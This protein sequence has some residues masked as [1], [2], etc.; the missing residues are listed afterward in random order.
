MRSVR[1]EEKSLKKLDEDKG[2]GISSQIELYFPLGL[3]MMMAMSSMF[4]GAV[5]M[6]S[7]I[8]EKNDRIV[9]II[10]SSISARSLMIGKL[11]GYGILGLFQILIWLTSVLL[12]ANIF[13]DISLDPLL[14]IKTLY[15]FIYFIFGFTMVASINA[16]I[17]SATKDVQ[18]G[19]HSSGL[20]VI[21]PIIP[22]YFSAAILNNPSGTISRL[23]S[24][25]PF[26]TATT[27]LIRTGFSSPP[28]WEYIL[29]YSILIFST[30][31]IL[32][33]ASKVFR[34]GMLMYGKNFSLKEIIKWARS[35][36]Y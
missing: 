30:L 24:Y 34:V 36:N 28:T 2:E 6:Q 12:A 13:F 16:M 7:I 31:F 3:A 11:I 1:I 17:G 35:E 19:S 14:N 21:I 18:S 27:M 8:K 29:T 33:I 20:L 15:M 32:I 23:L 4:S 9:E 22:I 5:L 26:T 10:L 25:I